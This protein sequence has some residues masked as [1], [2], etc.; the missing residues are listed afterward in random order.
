MSFI[1]VHFTADVDLFRQAKTER[2]IPITSRGGGI[3]LYDTEQNQRKKNIFREHIEEIKP[4]AWR[5]C[6]CAV[7]PFCHETLPLLYYCCCW[8]FQ[9][10]VR[11]PLAYV[12]THS[13]GQPKYGSPPF[14]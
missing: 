13:F 10:P 5:R 4:C 11:A 3:V 2:K 1:T 14:R 6:W 7:S 12:I 9:S 8:V